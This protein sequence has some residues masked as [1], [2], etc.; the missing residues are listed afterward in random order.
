MA[1][2]S[3]RRSCSRA[4][5]YDRRALLHA[6]W[7]ES[8]TPTLGQS[9]LEA[10]AQACTSSAAL[11]IQASAWIPNPMRACRVPLSVIWCSHVP[12]NGSAQ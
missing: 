3:V 8:G 2:C 6:S 9:G 11:L 4:Q 1:A 7:L 5:L 10:G 12:A